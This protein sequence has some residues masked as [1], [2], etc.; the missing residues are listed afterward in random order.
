MADP[1]LPSPTLLALLGSAIVH[2]DEALGPTGHPADVASFR[3]MLEH[4]EVRAWLYAM[5]LYAM[6]PVKR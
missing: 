2:A 5:S 4:P 1:L 3:T 6:L